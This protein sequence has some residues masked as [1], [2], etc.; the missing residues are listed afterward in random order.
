M[1]SALDYL[2]YDVSHLLSSYISNRRQSNN[3]LEELN[4]L[5]DVNVCAKYLR[6]FDFNKTLR[7]TITG[8]QMRLMIAED[9]I[10]NQRQT[11]WLHNWPTKSPSFYLNISRSN[12]KRDTIKR[13]SKSDALI[14]ETGWRLKRFPPDKD[15]YQI[16][17]LKLIKKEKK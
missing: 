9:I 1:I 12:H 14:K 13:I 6:S 4:R 10:I 17:T 7:H 8:N 5:I 16:N 2:D 3:V 15:R 11:G